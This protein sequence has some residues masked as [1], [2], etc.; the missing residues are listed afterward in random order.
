[1]MEAEARDFLTSAA[2]VHPPSVSGRF[3]PAQAPVEPESALGFWHYA[4]FGSI[5]LLSFIAGIVFKN[6]QISRRYGGFRI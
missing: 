3:L 1:M 4:V 2:G 5:I 6:R